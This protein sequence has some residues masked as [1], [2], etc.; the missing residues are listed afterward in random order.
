MKVDVKFAELHSPLF[1]NGKNCG[2]KIFNKD[3]IKI[4]YDTEEKELLVTYMGKTAHLPST[5]VHS[6]EEFTESDK[7][8][9]VGQPAAEQLPKRGRPSAQ[10][11]TPTGHVFE[12]PGNGQK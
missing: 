8:K 1:L 6:W 2:L 12:G 9:G 7:P 3:Q 10:A 4:V 11:S 5:S